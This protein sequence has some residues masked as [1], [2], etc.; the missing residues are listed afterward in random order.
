MWRMV[1]L[2]QLG[3][4]RYRNW[5][6]RL[7]D[8][9]GTSQPTNSHLPLAHAAIPLA[10]TAM[11]VS[12]V[13]AFRV[14]HVRPVALLYVL[15]VGLLI[16]VPPTFVHYGALIGVPAA[17]LVGTA[18]S[19]LARLARKVRMPWRPVPLAALGI[20]VV[21]ALTAMAYP[22]ATARVNHPMPVGRLASALHVPGCISF[23]SPSPALSLGL[24]DRN[25]DRGC[26]LMVDLGGLGDQLSQGT[27][28]GRS[29][30]HP[31][32]RIARR[33]LGSGAVVV[34]YR[35]NHGLGADRATRRVIDHWPV[36]ARSHGI[37]I[38]RPPH[39]RTVRS[40]GLVKHPGSTGHDVTG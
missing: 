38:R 26:P 25:L 5:T 31:W 8:I 13:L 39:V 4:A 24:V 32:Q 12:L 16:A 22:Q 17:I 20:V 10:L 1:V 40:A 33:Y 34:L 21:L 35:I 7:A 3:R 2:D 29:R 15:L 19:E 14:R 18:V 30:N 27:G 37:V 11:A 9:T 28:K 6:H 36:I 23:D